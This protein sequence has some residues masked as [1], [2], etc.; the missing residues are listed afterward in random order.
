[1]DLSWVLI[2]SEELSRDDSFFMGKTWVILGEVLGVFWMG[3]CG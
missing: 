2:I 3:C 1:M